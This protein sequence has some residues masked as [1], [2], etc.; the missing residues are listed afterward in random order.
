MEWVRSRGQGLSGAALGMQVMRAIFAQPLVIGITLGI[1]VNL[2]G[3]PVP[4]SVGAAADM[5]GRAGLP[6]AL[7]GLGGVLLRYR[8]EGD[9]ALIGLVVLVTLVLHPVVTYGLARFV[10]GIDLASL[11]SAVVTA[12][13]RQ[14]VG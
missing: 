14:G 2:A 9:K 1:V 4:L 13:M 6:A 11:R 3:L 7:F 10:F 8:P 12:A 5:M